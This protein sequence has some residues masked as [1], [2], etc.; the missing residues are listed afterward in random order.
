MKLFKLFFLPVLLLLPLCAGAADD[1]PAGQDGS[2]K[3][4]IALEYRY[5]PG[6]GGEDSDIGQSLCGTRCNALSVDYLNYTSPG[7]W[8]M[9]KV[10][11]RRELT[12]DPGNPFLTGK[13]ICVVDEYLIKVNELYMS[14]KKRQEKEEK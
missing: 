9:I 7:G 13:C 6:E 4:Y 8:R 2:E 5:D 1:D 3:V 12:I 14:K 11:D 10:A